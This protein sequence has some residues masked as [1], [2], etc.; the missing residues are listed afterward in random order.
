MTNNIKEKEIQTSIEDIIRDWV[1][2]GSEDAVIYNSDIEDL[3]K[4]IMSFGVGFLKSDLDKLID[5][6]REIK[7]PS[8]NYFKECSKLKR[9]ISNMKKSDEK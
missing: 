8:S 1:Y 5:E 7:H 2:E 3:A 6:A 9:K 4:R